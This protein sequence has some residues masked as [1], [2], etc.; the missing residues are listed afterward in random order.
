MQR[1]GGLPARE[2]AH[3]AQR[4]MAARD[5]LFPGA[6]TGGPPEPRP[7]ALIAPR[8]AGGRRGHTMRRLLVL[9]DLLSLVAAFALT[10]LYDSVSAGDP[11][12]TRADVLLVLVGAPVWLLLA[13]LN[14]L[15]EVESGRADHGLAEEVGPVLQMATLWTWCII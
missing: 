1:L 5:A 6:R 3:R 11:G 8:G 9:A 7:L 15:Y 4:A 2:R 10:E 13:Q 12:V 14:R